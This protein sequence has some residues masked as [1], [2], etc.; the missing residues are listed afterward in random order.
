MKI[1]NITAGVALLLAASFSLAQW[2]QQP[3]VDTR[4]GPIYPENPSYNFHSTSNYSPYQFN[5]YTGHWDYVPVPYDSGWSPARAGSEPPYIYT[6]PPQPSPYST[7]SAPAP[8]ITSPS[9]IASAVQPP[10]IANGPLD[11][12][13]L[14]NPPATQPSEIIG[15]KEASFTGRIIGMRTV[16]LAGEPYPHIL[17]RLRSDKGG[18]GTVDVAD[19]LDLPEIRA[20]EDF[21]VTVTGKLGVIDGNL[22]LFA[23]K[24][25]FGS[26]QMNIKR[27]GTTQPSR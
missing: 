9:G 18:M 22:V 27:P 8:G 14:W 19:R 5:W 4:V 13:G 17:L 24:V 3:Q 15:P 20:A 7:P 26:H 21:K 25:S 6:P 2:Q 16:D 1:W 11:D 12:S 10:R 23:D